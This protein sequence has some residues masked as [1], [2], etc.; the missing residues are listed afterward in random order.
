MAAPCPSEESFKA[1]EFGVAVKAI[2]VGMPC[3]G[4]TGWR[5]HL[6][7]VASQALEALPEGRL[8]GRMRKLT[9]LVAPAW[10]I[11]R[12][13]AGGW[14]G[15]GGRRQPVVGLDGSGGER[16]HL[17]G[18]GEGPTEAV[19][20]AKQERAGWGRGAWRCKDGLHEPAKRTKICTKPV[21]LA[22]GEPSANL[23][24]ES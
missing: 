13:A 24:R 21:R 16:R 22:F 18:V 7:G 20:E 23:R 10:G 5:N 2:S 6:P 9:L 17:F 19:A 8:M 12:H 1:R 4:P 15:E 11:G 14:S 3:M